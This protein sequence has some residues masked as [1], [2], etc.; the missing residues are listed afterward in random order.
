M[1]GIHFTY[2]QPD[3]SSLKQGDV[4]KKTPTLLTVIKGIH[5]PYALDD[6]LFFQVLTQTC[7]LFRRDGTCKARY[8]TI[9][10]VRSLKSV[11]QRTIDEFEAVVEK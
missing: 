10:A 4:L 9:A 3:Q 8:I 2:R 11:V 5:P 6:Y 7:D 1:D